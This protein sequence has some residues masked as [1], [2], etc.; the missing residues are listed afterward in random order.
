[1]RRLQ[2]C[3]AVTERLESLLF[4]GSPEPKHA[5]SAASPG[6]AGPTISSAVRGRLCVAWAHASLLSSPPCLEYGAF[7]QCWVPPVID[8]SGGR[9]AAHFVV[10]FSP[11]S[12]HRVLERLK[13]WQES[14][15][16]TCV[17]M[18]QTLCEQAGSLETLADRKYGLTTFPS[19]PPVLGILN[20]LA[21]KP[22]GA[23]CSQWPAVSLRRMSHF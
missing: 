19:T 20:S 9:M 22:F 7:L 17:L 23:S 14:A 3:R 15:P 5:S 10:V 16:G 12:L 11:S 21:E 18:L 8:S 6:Q 1:M 2:E 13:P 4:A